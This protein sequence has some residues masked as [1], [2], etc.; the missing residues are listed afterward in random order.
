MLAHL[1]G[2]KCHARV[3]PLI[4]QLV[5]SLAHP[6][7]S[8]TATICPGGHVKEHS[9]CSEKKKKR[10]RFCP[11]SPPRPR[12][13][14]SKENALSFSAQRALNPVSLSLFLAK[15]KHG[16]QDSCGSMSLPTVFAFHFHSRNIYIYICFVLCFGRKR[17]RNGYGSQR[18]CAFS[19]TKECQVD[20]TILLQVW[21][22]C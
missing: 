20:D 16:L 13:R 7:T 8:A 15:S 1:A 18:K 5:L 4:V 11:L 10:A 14:K 19:A 12:T 2:W 17:K 3:R 6:S 21:G 22:G 9:P